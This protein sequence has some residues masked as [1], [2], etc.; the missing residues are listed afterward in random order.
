MKRPDYLLG[1]DVSRSQA[2]EIAAQLS[3][4]ANFPVG[5]WL[6]DSGTSLLYVLDTPELQAMTFDKVVCPEREK[7]APKVVTKVSE[8]ETDSPGRAQ[9]SPCMTA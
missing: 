9:E 3:S 4:R 1:A 6:C 5:V 7:E 2:F 8:C